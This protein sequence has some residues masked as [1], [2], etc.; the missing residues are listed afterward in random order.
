MANKTLFK[1]QNNRVAPISA[2][3]AAGGQCYNLSDEHS[4]AQYVVTGTFNGAFYSTAEQQLAEVQKLAAKVNPITLAKLAVYGR[5]QGN[6]KDVPAYLLAVLAARGEIELVKKIFNRVCNNA[7]MLIN[8]VQ[9]IRSGVTGRKSFGTA[10][11]TLIQNWLLEKTPEQLFISS[12]GHGNPS[13]KDVVKM[14]HP[15]A[16]NAHQNAMLA[17][18]LDK[19]YD[20]ALLP[21]VVNQFETFKKD[22]TAELPLLP[23]FVLSNCALSKDNWKTVAGNMPWNTLRMNLNKLAREGVFEDKEIAKKVAEKLASK[24]EVLRNNAFPYELYNTLLHVENVPNNVR[25]A[26]QDALDFATEN[27]PSFDGKNVV[28]CIDV[29]GS[30]SSPVT[31]NR[32]GSTTKVSCANVA[33]LFGACLARRN[34]NVTI[35]TFDNV[36][37]EVKVNTRDSVATIASS[38]PANGGGTD[39]NAAMQHI[40]RNNLKADLI[41]MI[42]DNQSWMSFGR[43]GTAMAESFDKIRRNNKNT[44]L[45]LLDIQAYA[46]TQVQD[47]PNVLNI[48]GFSDEVW[49][50][51]ERF[52]NNEKIDFVKR[53]NE[54]KL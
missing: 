11:K 53:V 12:I 44:K 50:T 43:T 45:V 24:E 20:T 51:I 18:L 3:N 23:Y 49:P 13:L 32:P 52:V 22:N 40:L 5:E 6:M 21:E 47:S 25:N 8:F 16:K 10:L 30:M 33:V 31:G 14:V 9:I 42:S 29:S 27:T 19:D 2:V 37:R 38:I 35:I 15:K 1:S 26:L 7:K 36:A 46:N 4:L 17:Y 39:C 28:V 54:V 41:V 34:D 48:G